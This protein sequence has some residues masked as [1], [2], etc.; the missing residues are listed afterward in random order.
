MKVFF[1]TGAGADQVVKYCFS[2]YAPSRNR[3]E[4]DHLDPDS[5]EPDMD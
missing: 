4:S 2:A 5:G 3:C 1:K